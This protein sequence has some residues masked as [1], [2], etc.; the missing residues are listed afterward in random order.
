MGDITVQNELPSPNDTS[1]FGVGGP[2]G[3]DGGE[4][5]LKA[6]SNQWETVEVEM[7]GAPP[8]PGRPGGTSGPFKAPEMSLLAPSKTAVRMNLINKSS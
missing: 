7:E 8:D 1:E 3:E 6:D 4:V 5:S 2:I